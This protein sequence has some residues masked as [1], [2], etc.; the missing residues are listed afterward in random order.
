MLYIRPTGEGSEMQLLS[1]KEMDDYVG[2]WKNFDF[3]SYSIDYVKFFQPKTTKWL[4]MLY[5]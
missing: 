4:V 5:S 2:F 1:N 3:D